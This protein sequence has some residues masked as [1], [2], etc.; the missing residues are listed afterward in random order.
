MGTIGTPSI[1]RRAP[2]H[3]MGIR[4]V[5][6]FKGMSAAIAK[7]AAIAEAWLASSGVRPS[8]AH[9]V[10]YH[11]IDMRGAMDLSYCVPVRTLLPPAGAVRPETLPGGRF[12]HL[13]Y[14]GGGIAGNRALIEWVRGQQ[15]E[16]DRHDTPEGDAF[17]ARCETRL[18]NPSEE[19]RRSRWRIE[20]AIKLAE[21]T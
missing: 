8:G 15:L 9:F 13:V 19:P 3:Y 1:D 11:V 4:F 10:R 6:P 2:Q 20:V 17:A 14:S 18:T 21:E 16:F 7:H 12:A 5:T